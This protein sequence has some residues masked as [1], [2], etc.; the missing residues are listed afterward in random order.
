[1]NRNII[2]Q[3]IL[4]AVIASIFFAL[5]AIVHADELIPN[6]SKYFD[7]KSHPEV[8]EAAEGPMYL[9]GA[10]ILAIGLA[11][12]LMSAV[13][14]GKAVWHIMRGIA[15]AKTTWISLAT[16]LVI[17]SLLAGGGWYNIVSIGHNVV[18]KPSVEILEK[19]G[20]KKQNNEQKQN[21]DDEDQDDDDDNQE[22][23]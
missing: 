20:S 22:D 17:C 15:V 9:G 13:Y 11:G 3:L 21:Q 19:S 2:K 16:A 14:I 10:I 18:V 23:E 7:P 1:M 4:L 6:A 8:Y 12:I 5:A